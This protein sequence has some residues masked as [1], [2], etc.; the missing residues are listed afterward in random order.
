M[1]RPKQVQQTISKNIALPL[2][3][4]A[5]L[6]LELYSDLEEKIPFGAQQKFFTQLL[7]KYFDEQDKQQGLS[8]AE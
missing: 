7:T 8:H 6:E 3:L 1:G 2:H 5:R 4:A